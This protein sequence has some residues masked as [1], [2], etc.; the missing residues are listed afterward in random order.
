MRHEKE[1]I[2]GEAAPW[3]RFNLLLSE[4]VV[5]A[6]NYTL[7]LCAELFVQVLVGLIHI[8]LRHL[9]RGICVRDILWHQP[10]PRPA[11]LHLS[12]TIS[13][14]EFQPEQASVHWGSQGLSR[15]RKSTLWSGKRFRRAPNLQAWRCWGI[16]LLLRKDEK[17]IKSDEFLMLVRRGLRSA[18]VCLGGQ[19]NLKTAESKNEPAVLELNFQSIRSINFYF[20]KFIHQ[21]TQNICPKIIKH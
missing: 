10:L 5:H 7:F 8:E 1:E 14:Q 12:A 9:G 18:R 15:E 3:C 16:Y 6:E 21:N 4:R 13:L 2:D 19:A 20:T 17:S 11:A